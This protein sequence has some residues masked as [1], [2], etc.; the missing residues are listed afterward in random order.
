MK[1]VVIFGG[2]GFVGQ[3]I[4]RRFAE[5]GYR[6]IIPYQKAENEAKLRIYGNTGQIIPLHFNSFNDSNIIDLIKN[7]NVILNGIKKFEVEEICSDFI[8]HSN[9]IV[10]LDYVIKNNSFTSLS[11][12]DR[13]FSFV[14]KGLIKLKRL[15]SRLKS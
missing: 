4:T 5:K 14:W 13:I 6:I 1:T 12:F 15:F 11:I 10:S 7:A 2:S 8:E 3:H 9:S